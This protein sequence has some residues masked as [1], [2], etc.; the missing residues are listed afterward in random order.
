WSKTYFN[1]LENI[2][3]WCISRQLWW[4]HRI[5]AWYDDAGNIY[6]A[7]NEEEARAKHGLATNVK[8]H[9]DEDVLD[10]WFSAALWPFST[11]G[12][13]EQT[14]ELAEF[15]PT[16]VLVTGFDIIFFW[17]ARMAMM[18]LK[19][20]GEVPFREVCITGL[21]R[22]EHGQK[23]SKSKGNV[24]DPIDL[25]DGITLD[26]LVT[27]RT[28]GMMQ[29]QLAGRVAKN[30][31]REF[32]DGIPAFGT[33]ALRFTFAA[34]AS[35]GRDIN[36][37]LGR[38]GGY[39]NFCN[40]LWNATR[41]VLMHVTSTPD[42]TAP[43]A[44][45]DRWIRSRLAHTVNET[46]DR[47]REYR[48]DLA[49]QNLYDFTW[50]AY[51]DWYLE[52]AKQRLNAESHPLRDEGGRVADAG[53]CSAEAARATLIL[54]L[55]ALLRLLHP[56]MPFITEALW[57]QVAPLAG[58][59]GESVMI[60]AY[61]E[62]DDFAADPAA[63]AEVAWLQAVVSALRGLRSELGLDPARRVPISVH[64]AD[65]ETR[66]RLIRHGAAIAFLA[67][68]ETPTIN[69][70]AEPEAA[71]TAVVGEASFALPLTGLVDVAAELARLDKTI[72]RLE[73][74]CRQAQQKLA[75]KNFLDRAPAEVVAQAQARLSEAEDAVVR[76]RDQR[77]RIAKSA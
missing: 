20:T 27:K 42:F 34:L 72:A 44:P 4:G 77:K 76:Y 1:W 51:C 3:D 63:E 36:F 69:D 61:P 67:R 53:G 52:L 56:F 38:I 30:T 45:A 16:D 71:V 40:K 25:I 18:G 74:E 58:R 66:A 68:T 19:F 59:G 6:V 55:E 62:S 70:D 23:M 32:P 28:R 15:Y 47:L 64:G 5:P 75:N 22:D 17:V 31:R 29:P 43:L 33:D 46:H 48:F 50:S 26:A 7:R 11:L 13:P 12:W 8:L 49:A 37:D 65:A 39:R 41:F 60:A 57:A 10:T 35:T 9:Q 73:A 2:Q 21:I 14:P 24:L 54:V